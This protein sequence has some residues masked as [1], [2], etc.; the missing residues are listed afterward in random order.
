MITIRTT[1]LRITERFGCYMGEEA[2]E[3][4]AE[5]EQFGDEILT[6]WTDE[7]LALLASLDLSGD[8]LIG[9]TEAMEEAFFAAEQEECRLLKV[10]Q[11]RG[12]DERAA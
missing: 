5:C 8:E 6:I 1:Y 11:E 9:C 12:D 2:I 10:R 7:T 3:L 4:T